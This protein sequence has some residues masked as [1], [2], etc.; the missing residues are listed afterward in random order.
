M[1]KLILPVEILAG[2]NFGDAVNDARDLSRKLDIAYVTFKF[3]GVSVSVSQRADAE[4]MLK[5]YLG[6]SSLTKYKSIIG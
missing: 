3:H 2:T 4:D 6:M 1:S 5:E